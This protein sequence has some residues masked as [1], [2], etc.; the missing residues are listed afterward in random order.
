MMLLLCF[1]E[2]RLKL[3]KSTVSIVPLCASE[4]WEVSHSSNTSYAVFSGQL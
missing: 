2:I 1:N 3:Y 4:I